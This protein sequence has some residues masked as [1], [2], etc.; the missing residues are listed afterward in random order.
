MKILEFRFIIVLVTIILITA[1]EKE[2][3]LNSE[4]IKPRIVV[5]SVF[6]ADDTLKIHIS[7]SRNI[8]YNNGGKLPNIESATAILLDDNDNELG[9]FIHQSSGNYYL[10]S[11]FSETGKNYKLDVSYNNFDRVFSESLLPDDILVSKIDTSRTA[12]YMNLSVTFSDNPNQKNFY[13]ILF[14]AKETYISEYEFEVYDTN[15]YDNYDFCTKEFI[16]EGETADIDG[17]ICGAELFFKDE[18]FNGNNYTFDA[19]KYI[20]NDT[21]T[22]IVVIKSMSEELFKYKV[23]LNKYKENNNGPFSEPVQVFSNIE[24]GFGIFGGYSECR[25]T[26]IIQ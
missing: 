14:I 4:Q 24:N 23:S 1:C 5:N 17:K 6:T 11:P 10:I 9:T 25:D 16:I 3:V 18:S 22:L 7:E 15:S 13:S 12:N 20:S 8:L 2:I 21:D 26:I 19:E